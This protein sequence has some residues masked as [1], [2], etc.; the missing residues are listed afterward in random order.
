MSVRIT[1]PP[2]IDLTQGNTRIKLRESLLFL[3]HPPRK[4]SEHSLFY[5]IFFA[6]LLKISLICLSGSPHNLLPFRFF[7][8]SFTQHFWGFR[9]FTSLFSAITSGFI[10]FTSRL[11]RHFQT[12]RLT[13][14]TSVD[15]PSRETL[16]ILYFV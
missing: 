10:G 3:F 14:T 15:K 13:E 5:F 8:S 7:T 1:L 6:T 2:A 16:L 4:S 11:S 12:K 9:F